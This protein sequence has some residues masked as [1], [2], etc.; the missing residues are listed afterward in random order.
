M[1]TTVDC[2]V[3]SRDRAAQLD[4]LL[5][6]IERYAPH[7]YRSLTVLW[8]AST[9]EYVRGYSLC[10]SQHAN[11]RFEC[12]SRFEHNVRAWLREA[13]AVVSFLVD[14]DV[15]YAPAPA[16]VDELELPLSLRGGD[17]GYPFSLDGNIYLRADVLALLW[18]GDVSFRNPTELEHAGYLARSRLPFERVNACDPPCLVGVPLN[19]VSESSGMPHLGVHEYDL[20][21]QYLAGGRLVYRD[22]PKEPA[23]H[24]RLEPMFV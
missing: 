1:T 9:R 4:L 18:E 24:A 3:F 22:D 20:N 19:R 12:E 13:G 6:S 8:R 14:D 11:V 10:F 2:L 23:A 21:E 5:R 15:F 16:G 17:Y 7:L